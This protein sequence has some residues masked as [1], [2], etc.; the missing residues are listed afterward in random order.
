[1]S[2]LLRI[3]EIPTRGTVEGSTTA[4]RERELGCTQYRGCT[5][6]ERVHRAVGCGRRPNLK[7]GRLW[8]V[9]QL[10]TDDRAVRRVHPIFRESAPQAERVHPDVRCGQG[11]CWGFC[12]YHACWR[13]VVRFVLLWVR[14]V[15]VWSLVCVRDAREGT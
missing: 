5:F 11:R 6:A 8:E 14:F 9:T 2:A 15:R 12:V 7:P 1:M 4:N 13:G 3:V 10:Q